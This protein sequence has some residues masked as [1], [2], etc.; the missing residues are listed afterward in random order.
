MTLK[1]GSRASFQAM[2]KLQL[3]TKARHEMALS[4][5]VAQSHSVEEENTALFKMQNDR[6]E[7]GTGIVPAD[8]IMKRLETN[9]A[10]L[11]QLK[12]RIA[13]EKRDLLMVSRTVDI[14]QAR[15]RQLENVLERKAAADEIEEF[16]IHTISAGTSLP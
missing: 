1:S 16:V 11:T 15:L 2:I 3:L 13:A 7:G 9:K 8:L 10:K 14:L 4:C 6:F 5:L 12:E